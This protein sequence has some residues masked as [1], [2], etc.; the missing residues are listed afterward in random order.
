M[1]FSCRPIEYVYVLLASQ[2]LKNEE[3]WTV[4]SWSAAFYNVFILIEDLLSLNKIPFH[5]YE[6]FVTST[7]FSADGPDDITLT[8]TGSLL[9]GSNLTLFCQ[10]SS[11]PPAAL[12]WFF[13]GESLNRTGQA[14]LE[15]SRLEERHSGLY[16]CRA[17]NNKTLKWKSATKPLVISGRCLG[18]PL[19][20]LMILWYCFSHHSCCDVLH[21]ACLLILIL[22][23]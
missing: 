10:V 2:C 16:S 17:F 9:V 3:T 15:L 5:Q 1:L 22:L 6:S 13:A 11:Q 19:N 4:K 23:I 7:W 20:I 18:L 12:E 8:V 14:R 21:N